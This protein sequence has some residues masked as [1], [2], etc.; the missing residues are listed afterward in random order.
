MSDLLMSCL[1]YSLHLEEINLSDVMPDDGNP[2]DFHRSMLDDVNQA[3]RD[4]GWTGVFI[5][6]AAW[7]KETRIL[8]LCCRE[9]NAPATLHLFKKVVAAQKVFVTVEGSKAE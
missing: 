2:T 9:G 8:S 4:Y 7:D 3:A 6:N 5:A 1:D